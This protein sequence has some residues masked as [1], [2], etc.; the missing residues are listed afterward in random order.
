MNRFILPIVLLTAAAGIGFF[1]YKKKKGSKSASYTSPVSPVVSAEAKLDCKN[2]DQNEM[3]AL[4]APMTADMQTVI[5]S[6]NSSPEWLASVTK[7][8]QDAGRPL[9]VQMKLDAVWFLKNQ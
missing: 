5:N 9:E 2:C 1:I 6:I 8:A 4:N 7:K 3:E